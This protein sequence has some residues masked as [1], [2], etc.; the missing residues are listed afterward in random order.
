[1]ADPFIRQFPEYRQIPLTRGYVA[2]VDAENYEWLA[3][4]KWHAEMRKDTVYAV[5]NRPRINGKKIGLI[6]MH[7]QIMSAPSGMLTDHKN[8]D[9]LM[10]C[11]ENLRVCTI[12]QNQHN[13]RIRN[14]T[15]SKYKGVCLKRGRWQAVIKAFGE[16]I[17]L[18][19]YTTEEG[20]A[21]AY[22]EAAL[23]YHGEFART[24]G[25]VVP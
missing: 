7:R 20:A 21:R 3:Q 16:K 14:G 2:I 23:K 25:F 10:N 18:G 6:Y 24:N 15:S 9:G 5:R 11:Y 8:S 12:S 1:M 19:E 17:Y 4:W 22:D 13:Q